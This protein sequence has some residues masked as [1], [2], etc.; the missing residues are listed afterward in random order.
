MRYFIYLSYDGTP[1]HGWQ[2]QPNANSVEAEIEKALS[3][4]LRHN[5]EIVGAGR[6]D[7]GVH[8]RQMVAHFDYNYDVLTPKLKYSLNRILPKSI[9]INDIKSVDEGLHARFSAKWRTYCYYIHTKKDPFNEAYSLE[10]HYDL[11]FPLMNE[12]A[13]HLLIVSD[14][15]AFCKSNTD[16]ATTICN[17]V[18]A[19][20]I[21]D[22]ETNW[23]FVIT[24]NRFLRNMVRAIVGTLIDVGRKK[25]SIAEF[26]NI[27][28]GKNRSAAGES[29]P[30]RALFLEKIIY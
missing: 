17:V 28:S 3:T 25:I 7:T 4:I 23:H 18:E 1:F 8:A 2:V 16:V 11:N 27:V 20:W 15:S 22:G 6:T 9:A 24:S 21:Q 12:A 26:D 29:M 30:A 19:K 10:M 14:F 13:S 5:L